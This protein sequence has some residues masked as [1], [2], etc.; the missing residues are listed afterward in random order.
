MR[1]STQTH[2]KFQR[3]QIGEWLDQHKYRQGSLTDAF[4]GEGSE[5]LAWMTNPLDALGVEFA[6]VSPRHPSGTVVRIPADWRF[7]LLGIDL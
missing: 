5:E 4:D 7:S 2:S 3:R 1:R 6:V